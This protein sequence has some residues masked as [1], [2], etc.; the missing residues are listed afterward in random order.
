MS[1][2]K[3]IKGTGFSATQCENEVYINNVLCATQSSST[4]QITCKLGLNSG[5]IPNVPYSIEVLI[6]NKGYALQN[7]FY[8]I[9]FLPSISSVS[10]NEGSI[11]NIF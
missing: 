3:L 1:Y 8:R 9:N 10:K 4:T 7:S 11:F 2:Y 5:L 6:K